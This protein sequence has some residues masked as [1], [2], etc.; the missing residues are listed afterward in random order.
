M[1]P[2]RK[3]FGHSN[4]EGFEITEECEEEIDNLNPIMEE[5]FYREYGTTS[6]HREVPLDGW[7]NQQFDDINNQHYDPYND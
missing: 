1:A 6:E 2:K 5:D 3:R 4:T 7:D